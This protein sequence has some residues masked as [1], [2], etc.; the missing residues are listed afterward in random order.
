MKKYFSK[1][2]ILAGI[3]SIF[4]L[5]LLVY[6][7]FFFSTKE[8]EHPAVQMEEERLFQEKGIPSDSSKSFWDST[9]IPKPD[10][11]GM[12]KLIQKSEVATPSVLFTEYQLYYRYPPE[13]RPLTKKM[14]DLLDPFKVMQE[15]TPIFKPDTEGEI[16]GYFSWHS[17]AY[18]VT[19]DKPAIAWLEVLDAKTD[20]RVRPR[21]LSAEIYSDSVYGEKLI[22][23]ADYNDSGSAPDRESND[24]I[25]TFSWRPRGGEKLHGG[26]LSMKVRFDAPSIKLKET[27][28][29]FSFNSTPTIPAKFTGNYHEYVENGSLYIAAEID[30]Y[31]AGQYIIEGNLF[32]KETGTPYHWVYLRKY[33]ERGTSQKIALPFFGAIFH[34]RG[35]EEGRFV[36]G[37]L[38][39]HRMNLPYDPRKLKEMLAKGQ[40]IPTTSEPLQEWIPLPTESYTTLNSYNIVQFSPLEY[41][42]QD[43]KDRLRVIQEYA[44]DWEKTRGAGP[45][46]NIGD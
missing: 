28:A 39:G 10:F 27:E 4:G 13:S 7:L 46:T 31:K 24:H 30:I 19:E 29:S 37:N 18:M 33:L 23:T 38:R 14:V 41:Q 6:F 35:F 3:G 26:E 22:G 11:I 32:D 8:K 5:W 16:Q 15:K 25:Y 40:E 45:D 21:I 2:R 44:S 17:S 42:G 12:E 36:L 20:E 43:K 9:G 34:D 1:K